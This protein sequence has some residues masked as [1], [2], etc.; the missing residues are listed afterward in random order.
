MLEII[1]LVS[2]LLVVIGLITIFVRIKTVQAPPYS[3][4]LII[5]F[6]IIFLILANYLLNSRYISFMS[7][8]LTSFFYIL[9][10]KSDKYERKLKKQKKNIKSSWIDILGFIIILLRYFQYWLAFISATLFI[11]S[12]ISGIKSEL[13]AI[14]NSFIMLG[15]LLIYMLDWLEYSSDIRKKFFFILLLV[16]TFF[17]LFN[18]KW[19]A[20]ISLLISII[21][22][23]FSDDFIGY[24]F[25]TKV[26]DK[27]KSFYKFLIPYTTF[28]FYLSMI[29]IQ[30][31]LPENFTKSIYEGIQILANNKDKIDDPGII[32]L[33]LVN[34][35]LEICFFCLIW[36]LFKNILKKLTIFN[37]NF[38]EELNGVEKN[39]KSKVQE[40]SSLK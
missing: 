16:F 38:F 13:V 29:I 5:I 10:D 17:G 3:R 12:C 27:K 8:F 30:D 20:G 24:F 26:E 23:A 39:I 11:N 9:V 21:G 7:L 15:L 37:T 6:Q 40:I 22:L 14:L 18:S 19:W 25:K 32:S 31:I 1:F 34:G 36:W 28:I 33:A 4:T 35:F 2:L